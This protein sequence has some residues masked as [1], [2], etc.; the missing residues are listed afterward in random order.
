MLLRL[1]LLLWGVQTREVQRAYAEHCPIDEELLLQWVD[2]ERR[3]SS[4]SSSN[5]N[6]NSN[7]SSGSNNDEA[8]ALL[9]LGLRLQPSVS[10]WLHYI[11]HLEGA[12]TIEKETE[13]R[14]AFETALRGFALHALEAPCLW[15]AY[16]HFEA[17]ILRH[18]QQGSSKQQQLQQ[19]QQIHRIRTL[20]YRQLQLPLGGLGDLLDE[21]RQAANKP[22]VSFLSPSAIFLSLFLPLSYLCR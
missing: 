12:G 15:T 22:S 19:Q 9:E 20:F 11:R 14:Q 6:S 16:R 3:L 10:L 2:A 18:W 5:S 13:I 8:R 1:L 7:S 4:S 17:Q 21:Y